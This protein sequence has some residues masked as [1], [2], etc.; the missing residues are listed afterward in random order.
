LK[1]WFNQKWRHSLAAKGI[2]TN[3]YSYYKKPLISNY[4][5]KKIQSLSNKNIGDL[6]EREISNHLSNVRRD[7]MLN[8]PINKNSESDKVDYFEP[9]RSPEEKS[10]ISTEMR[11]KKIADKIKEA[12]NYMT[13]RDVDFDSK[14]RIMDHY[15]NPLAEKFRKGAISERDFDMEFDSK[16]KHNTDMERKGGGLFDWGDK[17]SEEMN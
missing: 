10:S 7:A 13:I 4:E 9:F 8:K 3:R 16:V 17:T 12:D 15:I 1:G 2:K 5:I 6:S 14:A 11:E